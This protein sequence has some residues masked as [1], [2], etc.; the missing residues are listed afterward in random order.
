MNYILKFLFVAFFVGCLSN[1]KAQTKIVLESKLK[2]IDNEFCLGKKKYTGWAANYH[3]NGKLKSCYEVK[4]GIIEGRMVEFWIYKQDS[5]KRFRDTIEL[6]NLGAILEPLKSE[7][8]PSLYKPI[9][10][11]E[12]LQTNFIKNG[13]GIVYDSLGNKF[14]EGTYKDAKQNGIWTYY[15]IS[16]KLKAKGEFL[17]GNETEFGKSGVPLS[18]RFNLWSFYFESGNLS[19]ESNYKDGKL[20]G[21]SKKYFENGNLQSESNYIDHKYNGIVKFYY[22][23]GNLEEQSYYVND[24]INGTAKFYYENGK[25]KEEGSRKDGKLNGIVKFYNENGNLQSECNYQDDKEDGVLKTYYENGQLNEVLN[26]KEGKKSGISIYYD[27]SGKLYQ[28]A[29]FKGDSLIGLLKTYYKNGQL[30]SEIN[31][32]HNVASGLSKTYD[33]DGNLE[34]EENYLDGKRSGLSKEYYKNGNLKLLANYEEDIIKGIT[35]VYYENGN[36]QQETNYLNGQQTG[37]R[38]SYHLN[39][40]IEELANFKDGKITGIVKTYYENGIL[41][42]ELSFYND[43]TRCGPFK[44]YYLN[45]KLKSKGT[46]DTNSL[47]TEKLA[48][49]FFSY[50]EDGSLNM[51]VFIDENGNEVDRMPKKVIAKPVISISELNKYYTCKCCNSPVKG[52]KNGVNSSGEVCGTYGFEAIFSSDRLEELDSQVKNLGYSNIYEFLRYYSYKY[53]SLKCARLCY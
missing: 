24:E 48:G 45:G 21:L 16:G 38:K 26:F 20:N 3:Q 46:I 10:R 32:S 51:H 23:N 27:G 30:Q 39:G 35:K 40:K 9:K 1:L 15:H 6:N 22:E 13:I 53:C 50:N 33:E 37:L 34:K 29:N 12:Y 25:L 14:G 47:H 42:S 17:N 2:N 44:I 43:T 28:E 41:E 11:K 19:E 7:N 5:L 31:Y 4:K 18:G 36:I 49:D 8:S 52:L